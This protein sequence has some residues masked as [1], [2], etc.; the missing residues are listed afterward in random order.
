MLEPVKPV[1]FSADPDGIDLRNRFLHLIRSAEEDFKMLC[2]VDTMIVRTLQDCVVSRPRTPDMTWN[3]QLLAGLVITMAQAWRKQGELRRADEHYRYYFDGLPDRR[4]GGG[5]LKE[6]ASVKLKLGEQDAAMDLAGR[7]V[8]YR[9]DAYDCDRS[10][11]PSLV[12]ALEF[13]VDILEAVDDTE[14]ASQAH[15]ERLAQVRM[16]LKRF[17]EIA[18]EH[19]VGN[20][21]TGCIEGVCR[22]S[23]EFDGACLRPIEPKEQ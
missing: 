4:P 23:P 12:K 7:Y 19:C 10:F 1:C 22:G 8:A 9:R 21:C 14:Q 13:Q 17:A 5:F 20:Q 2:D 16:E 15:R 6:W 3:S 18:D 11:L